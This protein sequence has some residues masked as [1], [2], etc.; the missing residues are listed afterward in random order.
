MYNK[1][2]KE[3]DN[4]AVSKRWAI[5]MKKHIPNLIT[6]TNLFCACGALVAVFGGRFPLVALWLSIGLAADFLDGAVARALRVQSELGKQLD[7]LADMVAFGVVPG[8]IFYVLLRDSLLDNTFA[9]AGFVL[10]IFACL[11]LAKFNL[12][13]RQS[14]SFI[15]LPTPAAAIFTM[16]L[17][18]MN[19]WNTMGLKTWIAEPAFLLSAIVG[20]SLLMVSEIPMFSL[21]FAHFKWQGNQIKFIFAAVAVVLLLFLHEAAP[22]V[23]ILTYATFSILQHLL[24]RKT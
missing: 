22:A 17:M 6:L 9:L 8:A 20:L 21:K 12:D 5:N 13:T 10:T 23:V 3:I 7:S 2:F 24:N 4:F 11:R 1:K 16:S 15:G 19:H 18:L 14:N